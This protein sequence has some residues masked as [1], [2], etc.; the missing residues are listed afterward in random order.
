MVCLTRLWLKLWRARINLSWS[1]NFAHKESFKNITLRS[2]FLSTT[3]LHHCTSTRQI[4]PPTMVVSY[5]YYV[6]FGGV[7]QG[8]IDSPLGYHHSPASHEWLAEFHDS[9]VKDRCVIMSDLLIINNR[10]QWVVRS[11]SWY[12]CASD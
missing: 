3:V 9:V 4:K 1:I 6:L 7:N 11:G 5:M 2:A 8:T 12:D 10:Q